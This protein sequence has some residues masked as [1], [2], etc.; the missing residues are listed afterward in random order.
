VSNQKTIK[1]AVTLQGV[2][3]Q[4]GKKTSL[5]IKSSPANSGINFVR[6]DLTNKPLLNLGSLDL[7]GAGEPS[8]ER[9]TTIG[10]GFFQ[11]QTTE[12]LLAALSGLGIDNALIELTG[13]EIP[14]LDGSARDFVEAFKKA[15]IIEQ[16]SPKKILR[17]E[18]PVWCKNKDRFIAILPDDNFRISYTMSYESDALGT[19]YYDIVVDETS[20]QREIASARTFCLKSEALMLATSGL[21]RGVSW[22]NALIMGKRG[23]FMN[24][25]RFKDEPVRHKVLD[26]IGDL[27][28]LG[29][30]IKGHVI[31][32]KSGHSLNMELVKKLKAS[33]K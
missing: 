4:T 20:F 3:L 28:L 30:P 25:L 31:A 7:S 21:G 17:I 6:I 29:M 1:S 11:I 12:H 18:L 14:G 33:A 15:G 32:V 22:K 16:P 26:L 2:G 24:K 19:Q 10:T 9:R 23:P 8:E 27:Y 5:T 13:A